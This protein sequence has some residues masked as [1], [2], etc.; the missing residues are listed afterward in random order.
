MQMTEHLH[1]ETAVESPPLLDHAQVLVAEV[2]E[3]TELS[4]RGFA[5]VAAVGVPLSLVESSYWNASVG[6][7]G[8]P[9][10]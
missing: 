10:G 1:A 3:A 8:W 9:T 5:R 4:V 2:K 7:G 6:W